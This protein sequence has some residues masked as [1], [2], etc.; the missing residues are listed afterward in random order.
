MLLSGA[1]V[2][3]YF[4]A[5]GYLKS[6]LLD[7]HTPHMCACAS[8]RRPH[9]RSQFVTSKQANSLGK[10]MTRLE[11][12]WTA[13][14]GSPTSWPCVDCGMLTGNF[15]E[16]NND[17]CFASDRVPGDYEQSSQRTPLC[18]W[19]ETCSEVCRFCRG[20]H[21]CTPPPA[22]NHWSGVANG[23]TFTR[24]RRNHVLAMMFMKR[25]GREGACPDVQLA[26][27]DNSS[28]RAA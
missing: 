13:P 14:H 4:F 16:G 15:C 3:F 20:V 9:V 11:V 8:Q 1:S 28:Q 22:T 26:G 27:S 2:P 10:L 6:S 21:G 17:S 23:R 19:C 5:A 24:A 12:L 25:E 18:T 7:L